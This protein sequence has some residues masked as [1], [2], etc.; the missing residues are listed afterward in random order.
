MVHLTKF[1]P[2]PYNNCFK[3]FLCLWGWFVRTQRPPGYTPAYSCS[4]KTIQIFAH[5]WQILQVPLCF[6]CRWGEKGECECCRLS[7]SKLWSFC[8]GTCRLTSW[9]QLQLG[10]IILNA[11]ESWPLE[12]R[13]YLRQLL[14]VRYDDR[15][16]PWAE[17]TTALAYQYDIVML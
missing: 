3:K 7:A 14:L 16:L 10:F 1:S 12:H 2:S 17:H 4:S 9:H 8:V 13:W 6:N 15:C 5:Y 11:W